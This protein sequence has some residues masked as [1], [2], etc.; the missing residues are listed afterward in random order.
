[1]WPNRQSRPHPASPIKSARLPAFGG[2]SP[3]T[4][5]QGYGLRLLHGYA[6]PNHFLDVRKSISTMG[7]LSTGRYGA[8]GE[9]L[10]S[11]A[12]FAN[13]VVPHQD[14]IPA[15]HQPCELSIRWSVCRLVVVGVS[16]SSCIRQSCTCRS[17]AT[18][19]AAWLRRRRPDSQRK[20]GRARNLVDYSWC[21]RHQWPTILRLFTLNPRKQGGQGKLFRKASCCSSRCRKRSRRRQVRQNEE[22]EEFKR[23]TRV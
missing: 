14:L 1:M 3:L 23:R 7:S 21:V 5:K 9:F 15:M 4:P 6:H 2:N 11:S 8:H 13:Q 10:V 12:L 18:V 22:S 19:N 16:S 20:D 17:G